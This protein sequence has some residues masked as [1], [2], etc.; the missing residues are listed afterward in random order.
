MTHTV[1]MPATAALPDSVLLVEDDAGDRLLV[2]EVFDQQGLGRALAS[3]EDGEDALD[4]LYRRGHHATVKRPSLILLD[5][6]LPRV[7]GRE[8][9]ERIKT[10]PDLASIPVVVLTTSEAEEDVARMYAA[11]ANAYV[12]KPL[13]WDEFTTAVG[14]IGDFY[15]DVVRLPAGH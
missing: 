5:L 11:H 4:Y 8:V 13:N 15:L 9:L 7:N 2:Q 1:P 6:N 12:T 10:E 3:V 14:R